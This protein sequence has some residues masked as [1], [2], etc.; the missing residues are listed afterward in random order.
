MILLYEKYNKIPRKLY[1]FYLHRGSSN[2]DGANRAEVFNP[3]TKAF[4][5]T[6][7]KFDTARFFA[8]AT[9]L[10]DGQVLIIGGYD[11]D[12]AVSSK[13]WIYSAG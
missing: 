11:N 2:F 6:A 7:G 1:L 4:E 5:V 10:R 9:L 3:A 8:T 13:A 12:N